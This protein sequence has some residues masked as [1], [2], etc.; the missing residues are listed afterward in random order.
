MTGIQPVHLSA[1][2]PC[3]A[4]QILYHR[5]QFLYKLPDLMFFQIHGDLAASGMGKD[6]GA[7]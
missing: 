1:E 6:K 4:A 2:L 5:L 7:A 3:M